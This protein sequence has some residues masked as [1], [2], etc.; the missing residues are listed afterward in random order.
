MNDIVYIWD[1]TIHV[2]QNVDQAMRYSVEISLRWQ[3]WFA[4]REKSYRWN[5]RRCLAGSGDKSERWNRNGCWISKVLFYFKRHI[6]N[7]KPPKN[8]QIEKNSNNL[9]Y[10]LTSMKIMW[11]FN[12]HVDERNFVRVSRQQFIT[13]CLTT[14]MADV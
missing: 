1:I 2:Q 6:Q 7:I 10:S 5:K 9:F 4:C 14:P 13:C 8:Y 3:V 12:L 11:P